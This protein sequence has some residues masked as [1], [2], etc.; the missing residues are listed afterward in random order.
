MAG[1]R[2]DAEAV[3]S[4]EIVNLTA[5]LMMQSAAAARFTNRTVFARR[6]HASS[7][8]I[9][10]D[11]AHATAKTERESGGVEFSGAAGMQRRMRRTMTQLP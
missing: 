7:R 1:R 11:I 4:E 2:D 9:N 8:R 10:A 6:E 5:L 3:K